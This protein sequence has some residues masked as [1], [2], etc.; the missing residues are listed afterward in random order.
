V[1]AVAA[2]ER[3]EMPLCEGV[4][5]IL[6]EGRPASQVVQALMTRPIKSEIE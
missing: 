2:R 3:I 6:Y 1:H 5:Q 4:Y